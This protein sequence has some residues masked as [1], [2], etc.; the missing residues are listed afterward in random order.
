[1]T[2]LMIVEEIASYLRVTKKTIYRLLRRGKIPATKVGRQWRFDKVSIDEW[3]RQKSVGGGTSILVIDDEK[4]VRAL[5][6]ETLEEQGHRVITAEDGAEGLELVQEQDFALVFL[7]L[8]MPGMDG[9]EIFRQIRT[10]KP[11]LPVTIITGYPD[12]E[13]MSRALAQGPF[14]VMNKPF[15]ESDIIGAVSNF[16]RITV[17]EKPHRM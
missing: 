10:I 12:S 5:F 9:T 16:L 13:M 3:L 2:E 4:V 7:D 17:T 6:K 14:G 15:S 1:M 8:K 11:D